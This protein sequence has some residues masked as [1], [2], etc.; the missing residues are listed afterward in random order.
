MLDDVLEIIFDIFGEVLFGKVDDPKTPKPVRLLILSVLAVA[1]IAL[2]CG[3]AFTVYNEGSTAM[4][5]IL[6]VIVLLIVLW[7]IY[8]CYKIIK[9]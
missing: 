8:R 6:M 1:M 3:L 4:V 9:R 7:W 2:F 5:V